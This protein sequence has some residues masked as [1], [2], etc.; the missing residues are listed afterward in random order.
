MQKEKSTELRAT[1]LKKITNLIISEIDFNN[2]GV[3]L[4]LAGLNYIEKYCNL[5][6]IET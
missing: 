2:K 5:I 3:R 1:A 4:W 6:F